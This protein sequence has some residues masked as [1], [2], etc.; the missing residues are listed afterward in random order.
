M[1]K[2]VGK[3]L[4]GY[5]EGKGRLF[6]KQGS[7]EYVGE[8]KNGLYEGDECSLNCEKYQYKGGFKEGR[9]WGTGELLEK[10]QKV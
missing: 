10:E 9:K 3:M 1:L 5:A 4:G 7:V 6:F 2:F 8:F